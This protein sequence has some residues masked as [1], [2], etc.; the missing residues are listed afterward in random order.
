MDTD[1]GGGDPP[2]AANAMTAS[3]NATYTPLGENGVRISFD[4]HDTDELPLRQ[5]RKRHR[6]DRND[7]DSSLKAQVDDNI[8]PLIDHATGNCCK[9]Y[10]KVIPDEMMRCYECKRSFHGSCKTIA[11]EKVRGEAVMPAPTYIKN[12]NNHL[13]KNNNGDF[14]GGRFFWVC[15]NCIMLKE[16]ASPRN[17]LDRQSMLEAV[18]LK[19]NM[20]HTAAFN[21]IAETLSALN[22]TLEK[23]RGDNGPP[24]SDDGIAPVEVVQNYTPPKPKVSNFPATP[25]AY[26][27]VAKSTLPANKGSESRCPTDKL[28]P[29]SSNQPH[30]NVPSSTPVSGNYKYRLKLF[31][32]NAEVHIMDIL[33]KL[34]NEG[35]L[36]SYDNY[37]SRGK[38]AIDLLF[39][40]SVKAGEAYTKLSVFFQSCTEH[41]VEVHTPEMILSKRV[42][43][44]G[45]SEGHTPE[46]ILSKVSNRY[47]E[48][49][50][51]GENR[52]NF[53]VLEPK[54]CI[55]NK[56]IYRS[57][58]IMSPELFDYISINL[59][60]RLR[61]G[62]YDSWA[63]YP[64]LNR[65]IKCQSFDHSFEQCKKRDPCC[66]ICSGNHF[67]KKCTVEDPTMLSCINCKKSETHKGNFSHRA[68][69][70]ECP[71]YLQFRNSK[72]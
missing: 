12:W 10:L 34:D 46:S 66:A 29:I 23:M 39:R 13:M 52:W 59:N 44:V 32:K 30:F 14:L 28:H 58:V 19:N 65:C 20:N 51:S 17:A 69:S 60:N 8:I 62:N 24:V 35:K 31:S 3:E 42:F 9:C 22:C 63:V 26:N 53:K 71:V 47:P 2:G 49:E 48:L 64:C 40:D 54:Q 43:L 16:V 11:L 36:D 50:L 38:L 18:V 27:T 7:E 41:D 55:R 45:M 57:T 61:M 21:Q 6:P 70:S 37:R 4:G 68:D 33:K 67:T 1:D 5:S 72:N 25:I 15:S 56:A